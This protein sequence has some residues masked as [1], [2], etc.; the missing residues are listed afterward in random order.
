MSD[1]Y[2][3][4]RLHGTWAAFLDMHRI[5][6]QLMPTELR[7]QA[8]KAAFGVDTKAARRDCRGDPDMT[9][10]NMAQLKEVL[11]F[12]VPFVGLAAKRD[13]DGDS[14]GGTKIKWRSLARRI[15]LCRFVIVRVK[16]DSGRVRRGT[17]EAVARDWNR[18]YPHDT[19]TAPTLA[20]QWSR[21]RTDPNVQFA[22]FAS[23]VL[24]YIDLVGIQ[25][26][27]QLDALRSPDGALPD[28]F[29]VRAFYHSIQMPPYQ[30]PPLLHM[31]DAT[32]CNLNRWASRMAER[33]LAGEEA[34]TAEFKRAGFRAVV[35]ALSREWRD[36]EGE[37]RQESQG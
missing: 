12:L 19:M 32:A 7:A 24:A 34:I 9:D 15:D 1:K 10:A 22:L 37:H 35:Q 20:R 8:E 27:E 2:F 28:G 36:N 11:D 14:S 4:E 25:V 5:P 30:A 26:D 23:S 13:T 29:N 21:A 6:P 18:R 3:D 17:W 16:A 33:P 31:D